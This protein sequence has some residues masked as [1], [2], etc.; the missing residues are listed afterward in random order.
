MANGISTLDDVAKIAGV[1]KSTASR[2]L[3]V[4]RGDRL[5]FSAKTQEKVRNAADKL[6][7][8]PSKLA[9]GLTGTKTG[10][11]GLVIPSVMDSFFP[12]VT[13]VIESLLA[14]RGYNVILT[15]TNADSAIERAKIADLMSWRVDGFIV[16]PSQEAADAGLYWDLWSSKVPFVLIDRFFADTPFCSVITDDYAGGVMAVE[17]LLAIGRK[18]I[19]RAGGSLAVSTNRLRHAGYSDALIRNGISPDERYSIEVPPT[20]EGGHIAFARLAELDPHPDAVFC[21]SDPVAAGIME[22]C[23]E[24]G[25]NIPGDLAVV[26]YADLHYSSLLRVGLTTIRQPR[27]QLGQRA[28]EALIAQMEGGNGAVESV[29][30]PVELVIRES[31]VPQP[32]KRRP[33][34]KW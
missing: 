31:T 2:I 33:A 16:A 34:A 10:I 29:K 27:Q 15:N 18:R 32:A 5:P 24:S 23:E 8:R 22:A 7:Y 21:F 4:K 3:A 26:G 19:A 9:R 28:A 11:V 6:G 17:H 12:N 14:E 30:L 20:G 1:C 25:V 13:T